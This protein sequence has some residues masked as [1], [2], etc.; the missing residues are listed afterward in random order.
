MYICYIYNRAIIRAAKP[1]A[2]YRKSVVNVDRE[3]IIPRG[4]NIYLLNWF[5]GSKKGIKRGGREG[6]GE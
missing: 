6:G 3:S 1:D 5:N 2:D 4:T